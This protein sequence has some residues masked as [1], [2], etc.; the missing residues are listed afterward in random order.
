MDTNIM[1]DLGFSLVDV[2]YQ[3]GWSIQDQVWVNTKHERYRS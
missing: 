1:Q 2:S 3:W